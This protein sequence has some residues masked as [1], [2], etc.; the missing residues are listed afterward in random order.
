MKNDSPEAGLVVGGGAEEVGG[1][2]E[3][4]VGE[5]GGGGGGGGGWRV[6][7]VDGEFGDEGLISLEMQLYTKKKS[8]FNTK[9][10]HG[11]RYD[12]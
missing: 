1:G 7:K 12:T 6:K 4:V 11:G 10:S 2:V 9:C 8:T 5:G 3:E